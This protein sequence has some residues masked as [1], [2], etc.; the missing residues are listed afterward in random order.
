MVDK[1]KHLIETTLS[2]RTLHEGRIITLTE[3][4]VQLPSGKEAKREVVLHPGAVTVLAVTEDD[5]VL[6]VRQYR[7]PCERV[8]LET[9]AGKL[10]PGEDPLEC[11]KR[12]LEE[13]TGYTAREW[14]HVNS[15]FTSPGFANELLHAYV[16]TDLTQTAQNLDADE[17]L[18]VLEADRAEAE[19]LIADGEIYDAKTLV[20]LYWW[21]REQTRAGK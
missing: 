18:D 2:T 9:P 6:L 3:Q 12:E 13:E 20:L 1:D 15:F 5:K 11:A 10:E 7:K 16:A 4:T 17:F 19:R 21:L 8:L 14:K